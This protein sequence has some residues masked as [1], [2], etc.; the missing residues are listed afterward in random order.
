M[1]QRAKDALGIVAGLGGR[2]VTEEQVAAHL[3]QARGQRKTDKVLFELWKANLIYHS[4]KTGLYGLSSLGKREV[5]GWAEALRPWLSEIDRR[6]EEAKK[7]A[8]AA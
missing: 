8:G 7:E 6:E 3:P 4:R 2:D 5:L 1:D